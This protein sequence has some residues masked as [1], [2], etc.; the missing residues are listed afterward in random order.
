T[1]VTVKLSSVYGPSA[2]LIFA[3]IFLFIVIV[4]MHLWSRYRENETSQQIADLMKEALTSPMENMVGDS[5][6]AVAV[7]PDGTI[8]PN[9]IR[10]MKKLDP[11]ISAITKFFQD[12]I[13]YDG[14]ASKLR[15]HF[16]LGAAGN[17]T[18]QELSTVFLSD[19]AFLSAKLGHEVSFDSFESCGFVTLLLRLRTNA[20]ETT[21]WNRLVYQAFVDRVIDMNALLSN[22]EKN[23][24]QVEPSG[25]IFLFASIFAEFSPDAVKKYMRLMYDYSAALANIDR[26]LVP[27]EV[28]WLQHLERFIGNYRSFIRTNGT[29]KCSARPVGYRDAIRDTAAWNVAAEKPKNSNGEDAIRKLNDL[30]GLESVKREVITFRNF[31]KIQ[32]ERKKKGLSVPPTSCHLVFSGNPGTGKTTIARIMAEI[33]RDLGVVSKG[34]LIEATR[35]DLVAGYMGQTAI[36]T[37]K[38]IDSALDGVLFIDEAYT[39]S[40]NSEGDYGQEAIDTLLKRMEDDRDRLVVIIAGYTNEIRN[41][42]NS[43]PGLSSR[44]NRYIDFP[45]YT[46]EELAE[47]FKSLLSKYDYVMNYDAEVA[48]KK[49]IAAAVRE[50]DNHFGNGRYVRNLFEKV[51]EKQ[52]NRLAIKPSLVKGDISKILSSDFE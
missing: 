35:A 17:D 26:K 15:S 38:V 8:N 41:F 30:I 34:H 50:K 4:T 3:G 19:I 39:L 24:A 9:L 6:Y 42:V 7:K 51:I 25:E 49:R 48:M 11:T 31:I 40:R 36:K 27:Q 28:Q 43:N 5:G 46:E 32:K 37:N 1:V 2:Y 20:P 21:D 13:H 16:S 44:F 47:I 18:F 23:H 10:C 29:I 14:V 22:L 45:D 33:F 12:F 52:A